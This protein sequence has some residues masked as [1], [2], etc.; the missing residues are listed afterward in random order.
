M[1]LPKPFAGLVIR[2]GY[3]WRDQHRQGLETGLK[4]RPCVVVLAVET[5]DNALLVTV[6]PITHTAPKTA[7]DAVEIPLIV[8][9]RLGLD[10][11]KSWVVTTE[12]NRFTWP[13]YDLAPINQTPPYRYDY[14]VVPPHLFVKIRDAI[15]KRWLNKTLRLTGRDATL[16]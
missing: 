14:G 12:V 6:A 2:Y 11:E 15:V 9:Q 3:L 1:S 10:T 16:D 13:S 8:K 4:D 5:K 7:D